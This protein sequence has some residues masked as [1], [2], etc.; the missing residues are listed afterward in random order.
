MYIVECYRDETDAVIYVSAVFI[1]IRN[2]TSY[3]RLRFGGPLSLSVKV[4][5]RAAPLRLM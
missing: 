1:P 3:T 5:V 2:Y 4:W